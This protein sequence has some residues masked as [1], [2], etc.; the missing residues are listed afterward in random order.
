MGAPRYC[1]LTCVNK[2]FNGDTLSLTSTGNGYTV[3]YVHS[4]SVTIRSLRT[5]RLRS[6]PYISIH[7]PAWGTTI[8]L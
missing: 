7:V 3:Y 5:G 6:S 8:A 4:V 2:Q 1:S